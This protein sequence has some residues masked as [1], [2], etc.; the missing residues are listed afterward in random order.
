MVRPH[1]RVRVDVAR[2]GEDIIA[3]MDSQRIEHPVLI[4]ILMPARN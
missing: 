4:G 1:D 2:L 3:V